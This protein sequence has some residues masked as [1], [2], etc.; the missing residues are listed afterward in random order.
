MLSQ[1][2]ATNPV[3]RLAP[4]PTGAQH[5]GNARTFL[6]AYWSARAQN[7]RLLLRIEDIDSPRVKPWATHQAIEDLAWLGIE[8]DGSPIIQ[9]QRTELYQELL[10]R[11]LADDRVYPCT[12]SRKDI[13]TAASAPHEQ[14]P[15]SAPSSDGQLTFERELI[16]E[17]QFTAEGQL[18]V[19]AESTLYPGTCSGWRFGQAMPEEGS[20]CLRF[21]IDPTPM[22]FSDQIAGNVHCI[23]TTA[24]GDF[25]VTRKEGVAAYQLA[26]VVDDIDAGVTEVVRG[27]DLLVS[28][29]RQLQLYHY[30]GAPPPTYAHAPLV[31]GEDGRRLAKR[32]GDTRLSQYR[33][34]GVAPE[35]IVAWAA[36][37]AM[38][39][40]ETFPSQT[41]TASWELRRWHDE[42]IAR[43]DWSQISRERICFAESEGFGC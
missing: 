34:Q 37:S 23:P 17:G 39:T 24:I 41:E 28:T 11:L 19:D 13:E 12:C 14:R 3:C 2:T 16:A 15:P 32:H 22:T 35:T 40:Q 25:P 8:H 7:A 6:I 29:F 33:E 26:V 27:D 20:Y 43:F 38:G 42:M 31:V 9:T 30:L 4:S 10:D 5:L 1:T 18:S 36:R 21:R